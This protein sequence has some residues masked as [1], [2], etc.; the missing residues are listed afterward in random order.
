LAEKL[1]RIDGL[2][3]LGIHHNQTPRRHSPRRHSQY[4]VRDRVI[5]QHTSL[6]EDEE[7]AVPSEIATE[8][9]IEAIDE[10]DEIEVDIDFSDSFLASPLSQAWGE[11]NEA[12]ESWFPGSFSRQEQWLEDATNNTL[13]FEK[14]P[15]GSLTED[16][17]ESITGLMAAWVRRRSIDAALAVEKLLKRVVDDMRAGNTDI[18]VTTRMYT[19]VSKRGMWQDRC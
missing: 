16:D 17:V 2:S 12:N 4:S 10:D 6:D 9:E 5:L 13:D 3:S 7:S 18:Q 14:V 8:L 19:I 1:V 11:D 15:L